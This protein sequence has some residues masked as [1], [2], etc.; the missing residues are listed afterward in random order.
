MNSF[1]LWQFYTCVHWVCAFSNAFAPS[2][3]LSFFQ[4]TFPNDPSFFSFWASEFN[5]IHSFTRS[6]THYKAMMSLLICERA[7]TK[8]CIKLSILYSLHL[9]SKIFK[10]GYS[11]KRWEIFKIID[12]HL[13]G[14]KAVTSVFINHSPLGACDSSVSMTQFSI[15]Q[16]DNPNDGFMGLLGNFLDSINWGGR[17][18]PLW[19]ALFPRNGDL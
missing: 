12:K 19:V 15:I 2:L 6:L 3:L 11:L 8:S 7:C 5:F 13:Y 18:C 1:S 16:E 10:Q 9:Q 14:W 4:N 17:T